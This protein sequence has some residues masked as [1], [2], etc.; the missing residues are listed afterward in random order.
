MKIFYVFFSTDGECRLDN[1]RNP[2]PVNKTT[3]GV[4]VGIFVLDYQDTCK[5]ARYKTNGIV[6]FIQELLVSN[7]YRILTVPYFEFNDKAKLLQR[8]QYL[9]KK[10]KT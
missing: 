4:K 8:V 9:E 1:K 5:G 3:E 7:G 2:I 10:L 6:K